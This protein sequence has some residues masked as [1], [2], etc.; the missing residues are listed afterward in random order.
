MLGS[1]ETVDRF[2][3][4]Y[5][6][7][8]LIKRLVSMRI[9]QSLLSKE[10]ATMDQCILDEIER[11]EFKSY[12]A[13]FV[14]TSPKYAI[15]QNGGRWTTQK[16]NLA[17][18]AIAA[19]LK[20]E[21]SIGSLSRWYPKF[22]ALDFD[23][24]PIEDV[25]RC[26]DELGLKDSNSMLC[27]S[28]REDGYHLLFR[29]I[30]KGKRM[31]PSLLHM[32]LGTYVAEKNAQNIPLELYPQEDQ[33]F[34]LPFGPN[35]KMIR[36]GLLLNL[37][38]FEKLYWFEKLDEVDLASDL[39][40]PGR[41]VYR[42]GIDAEGAELLESGLVEPNSRYESQYK[43]LYHLWRQGE[44][45]EM[46]IDAVWSWIQSKH[47]ELSKDIRSSSKVVRKEIARQAQAIWLFTDRKRENPA[48]D[49]GKEY[50]TK[51]DLLAI[52]RFSNGS[53]PKMKFLANLVS[54]FNPRQ[55]TG[56]IPVHSD[57]LIQWSSRDTYQNHIEELVDKGIV[58]RTVNYSVGNHAK[59]IRLAWDYRPSHDAI[60]DDGRNLRFDE[61][62]PKA[63]SRVE[64]DAILKS[65]PISP[66]RRSNLRKLLKA[67]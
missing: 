28:E 64:F 60:Q 47:N 56:H 7:G 21:Y 3:L 27:T 29:P 16:K 49:F 11:P 32:I 5:G 37:Q 51:S 2:W 9:H 35:Q 6:I 20:G 1:I 24:V 31:T 42:T 38:W 55:N 62:L 33:C 30:Y 50:L 46:A 59:M 57:L 41:T 45:R 19:H 54:Y 61:V 48:K 34:R 4:T 36:E 43:V 67:S 8:I 26:M 39:N 66:A 44:S 12:I 15:K 13:Y 22:G 52:I 65:I 10:G 18:P 63:F 25:Y 14:Q 58:E 17:D 23:G 40:L 53:L